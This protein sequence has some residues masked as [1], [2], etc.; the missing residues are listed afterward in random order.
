MTAPQP[1]EYPPEVRLVTPLSGG[2]PRPEMPIPRAHVPLPPPYPVTADVVYAGFWRRAWGLLVDVVILAL[3]AIAAW[4]ATRF[5]A[6]WIITK[7]TDCVV[8]LEE[9][10]RFRV[11]GGSDAQAWAL[12]AVPVLIALFFWY[13]RIPRR[14]ATDGHTFGMDQLGLRARATSL[15]TDLTIGQAVARSAIH[16][17]LSAILAGGG[18][19]GLSVALDRELD[20]ELLAG[21]WPLLAALAAL[22]SLWSLLNRR[23]QTLYDR[24]GGA[25]VIRSKET[26]WLSVV[27]FVCFLTVVLIPVGIVLGHVVMSRIRNSRARM[28]GYGLAAISTFVGYLAIL[29]TAASIAGVVYVDRRDEERARKARPVDVQA[30][31]ADSFLLATALPQEEVT[32]DALRRDPEPP[33]PRLCGRPLF[34]GEQGV[35][36]VQ[37]TDRRNVDDPNVIG[38]GVSLVSFQSAEVAPKDAKEATRR[39]EDCAPFTR[40]GNTEI[41]KINVVSS[42]VPGSTWS[43]GYVVVYKRT[44]TN[45]SM[46]VTIAQAERVLVTVIANSRAQADFVATVT[47]G[48]AREVLP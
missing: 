45:L 2:A 4:F 14:M 16:L 10:R 29:V 31:A 24:L 21:W 35:A 33:Q 41:T 15:E 19:L 34:E 36:E 48:R 9:Y 30:A 12:N 23:R 28:G 13:R 11:C 46:Y 1:P 32:A 27:A 8:E 47:L 7:R 22:P 6:G 3:I 39:V 40:T 26:E 38:L 5:L 42:E 37:Y 20:G 18:A 44:G 17:L 25:V 43:T